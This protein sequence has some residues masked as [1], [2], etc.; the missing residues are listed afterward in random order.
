MYKSALVVYGLLVTNWACADVPQVCPEVMA[1]KTSCIAGEKMQCS[2]EFDPAINNF[3]YEWHAV[4]D[5]GQTFDVFSPYYRKL[6]GYIP[7]K[8]TDA[9]AEDTKVQAAILTNRRE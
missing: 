1:D 3:R 9:R 2:K 8:C 5:L 6:L 4:N 7:A